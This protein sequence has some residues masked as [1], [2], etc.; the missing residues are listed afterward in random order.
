[1]KIEEIKALGIEDIEIRMS[2]IKTEI[3]AEGADIDALA[4]EVEAIEE[5][6]AELKEAA[7]KRA[8][9]LEKVATKE[10][11]QIMPQTINPIEERAAKFRE[12]GKTAIE[13]RQLLS[14][15]TLQPTKAIPE[16]AELS[17]VVSS[18]VDDVNAFDATG[19]G[20]WGFA[21]RTADAIA[22]TVTEGSTIGGTAG[23]FN[24]DSISPEEWGILDEISNQ[25]KKFT[26]V[27]YE[28]SI[29]NNA[30]LA[31][32]KYASKKI[33]DAVVNSA[34]AETVTNLALD[35]DFVRTLVLGYDADESVAGGTKLYLCKEDLQVLGKVRG[36]NEKKAVFEITF[37]D[38]NNGTIKDGGLAVKFSLNANLKGTEGNT[39]LYGQPKTIAMPMWGDYEVSTDEGG[40]Y[41]K[42][43][44]MGIRGLQTAGAGL[45]KWHGMQVITH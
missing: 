38:E 7:E 21:Y 41:F 4:K 11:E 19:A 42:R 16:V 10:G 36:T 25:V 35:Q 6:K 32:R 28:T 33:V 45:T 30:F 8:G 37:E 2:Q 43:N 1:M 40:D 27:N 39:M 31:L 22:A 3:D 18:I 24:K 23:T 17:E 20:A 5:R 9:L 29:R 44:M 12:S 26:N 14:T 15:G 34:L 13:L